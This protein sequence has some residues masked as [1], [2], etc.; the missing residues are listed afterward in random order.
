[1]SRTPNELWHGW[2]RAL[3]EGQPVTAKAHAETLLDVIVERGDE[4]EWKPRSRQYFLNW[5]DQE[6][7]LIR[8]RS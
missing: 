3:A 7:L 2:L 4:P 5:C 8:G 6:R 1:M